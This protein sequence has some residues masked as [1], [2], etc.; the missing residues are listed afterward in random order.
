MTEM[1]LQSQLGYTQFLPAVPEAW[2]AGRVEGLVARGNFVI[3]QAWE[4]GVATEFAVTS[5]SGGTFVGQHPGIAD[6]VVRDSSGAVVETVAEG[7]DQISFDTVE[8]E[9]YRIAE[10]DDPPADE[11]ADPGEDAEDAGE[12]G[13]DADAA[14]DGSAEGTGEAGDDA[15]DAGEAGEDGSADDAGEA[16]DDGSA[17]D[18]G[19]G[20]DGSGS[21]G[22]DDAPG[23]G[24]EGGDDGLATT[25]EDVGPMLA[26]GAVRV[27][28]RRASPRL[29]SSRMAQECTSGADMWR[30]ICA[31]REQGARASGAGLGGCQA[32][33]WPTTPLRSRALPYLRVSPVRTMRYAARAAS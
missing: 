21:D 12:A 28:A 15:G 33:G 29:L 13:D 27:S 11:D 1:L 26:A 2:S 32:A 3:D 23:S 6:L 20:S 7:S 8:G 10:A 4:D 22:G 25:G 5:R 24:D 18:A 19:A 30:N 17:E 14:A 9:T 16:A 31:A